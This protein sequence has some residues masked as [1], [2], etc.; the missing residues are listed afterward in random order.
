MRT[1]SRNITAVLCISCISLNTMAAIVV[2]NMDGTGDFLTIQ[3]AI[4]S[5]AYGDT[6]TVHAGTYVEHIVLKNGVSLIA[7]DTHNTIIDGNHTGTVITSRN[8]DP[9]TI[10]N[11]FTVT[12]GFA[13]V[14]GG[15]YNYA[16]SPTILHCTFTKNSG[17]RT[18]CGMANMYSS[19]PQLSNCI[20]IENTALAPGASGGGMANM[21]GSNS[22]V[23]DS[24]FADN[25]AT[26]Y[27]GGIY[28]YSSAPTINQCT[29]QSNVASLGA[30]IMNYYESSPSITDC[31]FFNNS[32][33]SSGGG[34]QNSQRC[35][36]TILNCV[37]FDNYASNGG[38]GMI[39]S[40][41][42]N[43]LVAN[44]LFY[45]NRVPLRGGA[46]YNYESNPIFVNCTVGNNE[47]GLQ[48]GGIYNWRSSSPLIA[49]CI[50]W[51]NMAS[52][53]GN[54]IFN[55]G[56][57]CIPIIS[58]SDIRGCNG[59]SVDWDGSLGID[60]GG[61][62]DAHPT[63][64]DVYENDY[65]LTSK[66]PCID[67]GDPAS[68]A[69][70]GTTDLDG[71]PRIK[72]GRVDM[73]AY[74]FLPSVKVSV[75]VK[76]A[77]CP[78]QL[79]V[80]SKGILPVA[81]L[82]SDVLN[83]ED[84]DLSSVLLEGVAPLRGSYEDV[85]RP[86]LDEMECACTSEGSDGYMD[87]TLKFRTEEIV[88]A[89]GQI[90]DDDMRILHLTGYLKDG[91]PIEGSDCIIIKKPGRHGLGNSIDFAMFSLYWRRSDCNETNDWCDGRDVNESGE[92]DMNDLMVFRELWFEGTSQ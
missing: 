66:S 69:Q 47:A 53:L 79:N 70:P 52:G 23:V 34:L 51:G 37:F 24:L 87:L 57:S 82:G 1:L 43:P 11:G 36:P 89:L 49:N 76:P 81:I 33:K 44:S 85:A 39:N 6:I 26:A 5:A 77:S 3:D 35:S 84:I 54:E 63:F 21:Y 38:A 45:G 2:V 4:D 75:D 73:G 50:L 16:S 22:K 7:N 40:Q 15:M 78:N 59:S 61:N 31:L 64:I 58:Y 92:I 55:D 13:E 65:R 56:G 86:V 29:F 90:I 74:E 19:K 18:G 88:S 41:D 71:K 67:T 42:C 8:C 46:I 30:G 12:N 28:N 9:N 32:A 72:N 17:V 14:G 62:I 68:E 10:L 27:G 25:S 83:V 60:A 48:G 91:T 80:K 20:F